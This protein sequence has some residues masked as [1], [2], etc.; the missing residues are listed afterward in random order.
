MARLPESKPAIRCA[1]TLSVVVAWLM[2]A[3]LLA[4]A[5]A[6]DVLVSSQ[7]DRSD[8]HPLA[9]T[10][11]DNGAQV[12]I[13]AEPSGVTSVRFYLDDPTMSGAPRHVEFFEPYDFNGTA[14]DGTAIAFDISTLEPGSHTITAAQLQTDGQT[15][16]ESATF[17][18]LGTV[19]APPS[20]PT[21]SLVFEDNFDGSTLDTSK[22]D[23]Y[24][25]VGNNGN[26][27]RRPSAFTVS[28]G[29]LIVTAQMINKQLVTGGMAMRRDYTYGRME[30]RVRAEADP[31]GTL[32]AN[33][34]TWPQSGNWPIDGEMDIFETLWRPGTRSPFYSFIHYGSDNQQQ[35]TIHQADA[36]QWHTMALDWS[37]SALKIYR[38]GEL[39]WTLTDPAAIP[40]VPH[41]LCVQL[42]AMEN[43]ALTSRVRMY[44]DYVRIYQ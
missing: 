11:Y 39:A 7:P 28:G 29:N 3:G 21:D 42:D 15:R 33:V 34:L 43:Q 16:V 23:T 8:S 37:P 41:H 5:A 24:D 22:W 36:S 18:V 32:N 1:R 13:S 10:S 30:F 40:D 31:S 38:D 17:D 20:S 6:A 14:D 19:D 9:G 44:V 26:G 27:L 12:Y 4:N 35:Y 25:S 2:L